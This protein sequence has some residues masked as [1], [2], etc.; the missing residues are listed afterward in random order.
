MEVTSTMISEY[1]TSLYF[2]NLYDFSD[3]EDCR[4]LKQANAGLKTSETPLFSV[5]MA[6]YNDVS[7]FHSAVNSLLKQSCTDWE[8]LI[9]DNSDRNETAWELIQNAA[10]ADPRIRAYKSEQNVGWPKGASIL[11]EHVRG[12]Y[13]TF[14][15]AD[16]CI[17]L[18]SFESLE[19]VT[20]EE[21]DVIWVGLHRVSYR[22]SK[23]TYLDSQLPNYKIYDEKNRSEAIAE[24]AGRIYYNSFFH[25]I[26]VDFLR[27]QGI[28]FF[29]P[30]YA[31]VAGMTRCM[32]TA[33]KMIT[34]DNFVYCL[35][36]NTSQTSG[37][38]IWDSYRFMFANQWNCVKEVFECE[39]YQNQTAI[40]SVLASILTNLLNNISYLCEGHC[41]NKYMNPIHK[42][43]EEIIAH[44]E[45]ILSCD[46]V[47]EMLSFPG[48]PFDRLLTA[49]SSLRKIG[50]QAD[51]PLVDKSWL[52]P[53]LVLSLQK[54][55]SSE[56]KIVW[57]GEWLLHEKNNWCTGFEYFVS[58]LDGL[59]DNVMIRYKD[60]IDRIIAKFDTSPKCLQHTLLT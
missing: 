33:R 20:E 19:K 11:L 36:I 9:L 16:D 60:L 18:G 5:M 59:S 45:K 57:T 42:T 15:A 48:Y 22:D 17:D 34:M 27:E 35:T 1:L 50:L 26:R 41:R 58:L 23:I 49:I 3:A 54:D 31:D 7:L 46:E 32:T 25:Y 43:P 47:L 55:L 39:H 21:P 4:R 51:S 52:R 13:T 2:D 24:I 10:N 38:Y 30:Y 28:D 14:L 8:L 6:V 12:K 56:D 40:L 53:L 37:H 44:L 29:D